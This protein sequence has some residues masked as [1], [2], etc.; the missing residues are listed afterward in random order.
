MVAGR[1]PAATQALTWSM[2]ADPSPIVTCVYGIGSLLPFGLYHETARLC[3]VFWP[4]NCDCCRMPV[5]KYLVNILHS[6]PYEGRAMKY[7]DLVENSAT[8][9][10]KQEFFVGGD[11]T[12]ITIRIL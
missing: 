6:D 4:T 11:M 2:D 8:D 1:L 12:A 9:T 5:I 7:S 3:A 10:E